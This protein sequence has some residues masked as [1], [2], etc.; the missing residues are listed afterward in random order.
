[1][2]IVNGCEIVDHKYGIQSD[3][4]VARKLYRI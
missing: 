1:M 4:Q 2:K 3:C